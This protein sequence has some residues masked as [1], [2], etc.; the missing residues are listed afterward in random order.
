MSNSNASNIKALYLSYSRKKARVKTCKLIANDI[1]FEIHFNNKKYNKTS[2]SKILY[3]NKEF[4]N[5]IEHLPKTGIIVLKTE[6]GGISS[7]Y[8]LLLKVLQQALIEKKV[9]YWL[10]KTDS[11]KN[12]K[13]TAGGPKARA[14]YQKSYR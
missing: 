9:Y 5:L 2:L 7:N 14:R 1:D 6:G 13:K 3:F 11:R 4:T 10:T 8:E 12:Y